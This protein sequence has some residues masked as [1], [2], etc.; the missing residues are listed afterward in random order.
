MSIFSIS[1]QRIRFSFTNAFP[2]KFKLEFRLKHEHKHK[3]SKFN[4][5][6][7]LKRHHSMLKC[8]PHYETHHNQSTHSQPRFAQCEFPNCGTQWI[9]SHE[10]TDHL[11]LHKLQSQQSTPNTSNDAM[12]ALHTQ[13]QLIQR[14]TAADPRAHLSFEC[15]HSFIEHSKTCHTNA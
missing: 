11:T 7:K 10:Y 15:V 3:L 12:I 1:S 13:T 4:P 6:L 8:N 2:L 9:P 5:K 14:Q